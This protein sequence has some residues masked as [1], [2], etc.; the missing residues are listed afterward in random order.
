MPLITTEER[1][2]LLLNVLGDDVAQ[3]AFQSMNP[4]RANFIRQLLD[5]FKNNPPSEEEVDFVLGD[6]NQY[7]DFALNTLSPQLQPN[8]EDSNHDDAARSDSNVIQF[9]PLE[10]TDD[11]I[12]DL[13]RLD[14]WQIASAIAEDHPKT[15][16]LVAQALSTELAAKVLEQLPAD[17]RSAAIIELSKKASVAPT[18]L[19]SMLTSIVD[20]A[21]SIRCRK[22]E[23][24]QSQ[25]LAELMRSFPKKL[26]TELMEKL[27][28]TDSDLCQNVKSNLYL[29][30]DVLRLDDRDVQKILGE[31]ETDNLIVGLQ[32]ADQEIV[33]KLL[34][35]LSKRARETILE[36]MQ[37]KTNAT[38]EEIELARKSVIEVLARLDESGDITL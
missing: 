18:V 38:D 8:E 11:P 32:R 14:P 6:F 29:F 15:V 27:E 24:D 33:D 20:K 4:T 37:Y 28:E 5:D 34:N 1:I 9:P 35:N 10:R 25:I 7:F 3:V 13:N 12:F 30:E 31:V 2:A 26:R 22:E 16:A 17:T 36:E 21:A 19:H 23:V